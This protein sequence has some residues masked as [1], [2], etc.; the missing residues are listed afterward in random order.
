MPLM[1]LLT[2]II[3][4]SVQAKENPSLF[5]VQNMFHIFNHPY[6]TFSNS[7]LFLFEWK[8]GEKQ[9]TVL[10]NVL[11]KFSILFFMPFFLIL[12]LILHVLYLSSQSL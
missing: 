8:K 11:M 5:L 7:I 6:Y 1:I 3:C 10:F 2:S 12:N 4:S 9:N